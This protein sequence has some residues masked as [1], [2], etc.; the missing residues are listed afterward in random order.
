MSNR[1]L[2]VETHSDHLVRRL[3]GLVARAGR[4][5]ELEAWLL[6]NVVVLSV[7]QDASGRSTVTASRL[8]AEGG[9]GEI[10]PADFMDEA[11]DEES[12]IFYA[13]LDK[14]EAPG[15]NASPVEMISGE[16]PES[17]EAP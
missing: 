4:G 13:K 5:S 7:E 15:P 14:T 8:T 17:D 12:A 6:A 1:R 11:T 10:W 2:L 9:V 3:R 16:E